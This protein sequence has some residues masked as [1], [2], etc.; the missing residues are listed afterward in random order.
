MESVFSRT[1]DPDRLLAGED[2][3]SDLPEDADHWIEVYAELL[4]FKHELIRVAENHGRRVRNE[5][6]AE[7]D[8]DLEVMRMERERLLRRLEFWAARRRDLI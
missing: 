5:G 6:Q 7:V 2:P 3:K 8:N 4:S 1:F